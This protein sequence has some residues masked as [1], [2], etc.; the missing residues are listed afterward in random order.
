MDLGA[1]HKAMQPLL[2]HFNVFKVQLL[3][4]INELK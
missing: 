3:S 1:Q 2:T 4:I